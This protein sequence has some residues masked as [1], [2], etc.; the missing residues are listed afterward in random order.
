MSAI[1]IKAH[2]PGGAPDRQH[3]LTALIA[4]TAPRSKARAEVICCANRPVYRAGDCRP[5]RACSTFGR[6]GQNRLA[7]F[8]LRMVEFFYSTLI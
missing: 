5:T 8:A 6:R 3:H 2:L 7:S 4:L 1:L